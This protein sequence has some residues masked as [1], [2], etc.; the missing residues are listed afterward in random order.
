MV[1][2]DNGVRAL[3]PAPPYRLL[4]EDEDWAKCRGQGFRQ[5]AGTMGVDVSSVLDGNS[6][7][8]P[9]PHTLLSRY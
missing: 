6:P 5:R 2:L 7:Q 8:A 9:L 3:E 4:A 1:L